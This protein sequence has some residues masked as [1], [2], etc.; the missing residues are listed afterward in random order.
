MFAAAMS[1]F[2][3]NVRSRNRI[4]PSV[5]RWYIHDSR[6]RVNMFLLRSASFLPRPDSASASRVMLVSGT[7]TSCQPSSEPSSSGLLAYPTFARLR[8][9]NSSESTMSRPPPG[10]SARLAFS[11]A[12]FMAT[13]TSGASPGVMMSWS[14]KCSWKE[15]TPGRVPVGARIS[16]GKLGRVDRSLPKL[17]VSLVNRLPVSCMPSPES[18]A[19]RITTRSSSTTLFTRPPGAELCTVAAPLVDGGASE[20]VWLVPVIS[21]LPPPAEVTCVC[22]R[23]G[24]GSRHHDSLFANEA[25]PFLIPMRGSSQP[26]GERRPP[27][28][29]WTGRAALEQRT[30]DGRPPGPHGWAH[31]GCRGPD[32]GPLGAADRTGDRARVQRLCLFQLRQARAEGHAGL[33]RHRDAGAAALRDGARAGHRGPPADAPPLREPDQSAQRVRHRP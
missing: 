5:G 22:P 3:R 28:W 13:S 1:G 24:C 29:R 20:R 15:L 21:G 12:G 25:K 33:S 17:A 7:L 8:G 30:Q 32:R 6:P 10:R 31:C 27:E 23:R 26:R 19:S 4:V 9:V 11:A 16:A 2:R 18:P 14:A